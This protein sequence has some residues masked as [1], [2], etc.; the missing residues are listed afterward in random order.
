MRPGIQPWCSAYLAWQCRFRE[1]TSLVS[2]KA[3]AS[4]TNLKNSANP[5]FM[6]LAMRSALVGAHRERWHLVRAS[7]T[8]FLTSP[9]TSLNAASC[10]RSR[11]GVTMCGAPYRRSGRL[12]VAR[13]SRVPEIPASC[14][15]QQVY[16]WKRERISRSGMSTYFSMALA[17]SVAT[18]IAMAKHRIPDCAYGAFC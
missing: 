6:R 15:T 10:T 16:Q 8:R 4:S 17:Y 3:S 7:R 12:L 14:R 13:Q 5:D 2:C 1:K 18:D 11:N 9:E